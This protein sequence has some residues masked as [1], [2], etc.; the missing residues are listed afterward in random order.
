MKLH[1]AIS[2]STKY[3]ADWQ[4]SAQRLCAG[5]LHTSSTARLNLTT[6]YACADRQITLRLRS[7]KKFCY[8]PG[9]RL[10]VR[11]R[12][13][14]MPTPATA[15]AREATRAAPPPTTSAAVPAPAKPAPARP[16][17]AKATTAAAAAA[18]AA[19][20]AAAPAAVT[21]ALAAVT[22]ALAAV[23]A[24]KGTALARLE[25]RQRGRLREVGLLGVPARQAA[26]LPAT[27]LP[28]ARLQELLLAQKKNPANC[29][30]CYA[31]PVLESNFNCM[32]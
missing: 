25:L 24:A 4:H 32:P 2:S 31:V 29:T 12:Y 19:A 18:K 22:P 7:P 30:S 21:P 3:Y 28:P 20:P 17:A 6:L 15:T 14:S 23:P 16:P 5:S 10:S 8:T 27:V 11:L 1:S 26:R 13:S 9:R